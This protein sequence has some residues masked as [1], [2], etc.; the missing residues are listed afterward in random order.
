MR[1]LITGLPRSRTAWFSVLMGC[2]HE[3]TRELKGFDDLKSKWPDNSGISDAALGF[4]LR[5]I[6]DEIGPRVLIVERDLEDVQASFLKYMHDVPIR[7]SVLTEHLTLLQS[8][9]ADVTTASNPLVR[10]IRYEALQDLNAVKWAMGW[11]SPGCDMSRAKD[12]MRMNVQ[13]DRK[14]VIEELKAEHT[15]WHLAA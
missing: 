9:L 5:R 4:Q 3:I 10:R 13:V 1:Y 15:G 7:L 12:V 14:Y 11:L 2:R 8:R 6:V